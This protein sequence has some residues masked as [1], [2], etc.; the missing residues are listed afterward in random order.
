[1]IGVTG[2]SIPAANGAINGCYNTTTGAL[3]VID[4]PTK[5]CVRGERF[6]RWNQTG[7][8]NLAALQNT[9]C[10]AGTGTAGSLSATVS[11]ANGIVTLQCMTRLSVSSTVTMT[12]IVL[13]TDSLTGPPTE[14]QTATSCSQAY[15]LGTTNAYV[16]LWASAAFSYTCPGAQQLRSIPIQSNLQMGECRSVVMNTNRSVA[17]VP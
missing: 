13:W 4:Y 6:L 10:T 7:P 11:P 2:A 8:A 16:Q 1:M 15:G 3:R 17:V 14:C 12:R 5:R 9:P